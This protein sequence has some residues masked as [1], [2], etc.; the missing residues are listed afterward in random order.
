MN[1]I[2][3]P[4]ELANAYLARQDEER[5]ALVKD[6]VCGDCARYVGVPPEWAHEPCGYC[7]ECGEH[8]RCSDSVEEFDCDRYEPRRY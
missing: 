1:R 6:A 3:E 8:V 7:P 4:H 5:R 2:P